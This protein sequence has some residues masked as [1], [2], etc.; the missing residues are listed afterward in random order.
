MSKKAVGHKVQCQFGEQEGRSTAVSGIALDFSFASDEPA[1][2]LPAG[3]REAGRTSDG[4]ASNAGTRG[5]RPQMK[6]MIQLP[7]LI[8][9]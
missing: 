1:P 6:A 7:G 4:Q 5:R 2:E 8:R 9:L 3:E